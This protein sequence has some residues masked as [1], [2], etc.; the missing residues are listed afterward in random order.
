M[1]LSHF[2][3]RQQSGSYNLSATVA[4]IV[5][6]IAFDHFL[7]MSRCQLVRKSGFSKCVR[8]SP[9][10][11]IRASHGNHIKML[12]VHNLLFISFFLPFLF[13]TLHIC[14]I[15]YN[16]HTRLERGWAGICTRTHARIL[17]PFHFCWARL[18]TSTHCVCHCVWCVSVLH[19]CRRFPNALCCRHCQH[20]AW[21]R[22]QRR[23]AG[24]GRGSVR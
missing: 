3:W 20:G 12:S 11:W 15:V 4:Q 16:S 14:G 24:Q 8:L 18:H 5:F 23:A 7:L 13:V 10:E 17:L 6:P 22:R 19:C 2:F 1:F 21:R 9:E